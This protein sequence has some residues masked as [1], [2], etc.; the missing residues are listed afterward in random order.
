MSEIVDRYRTCADAFAAKITAVAPD[1]WSEQ[2]PCADWKARDVVG[3][4]LVMHGAMLQPLGRDLSPA[5]SID[6][7]PLAAFRAARADI[8]ALLDDP[9][10]ASA[11]TETPAGRMSIGEH[12][13]RVLSTDLVLHGWDLA[14]ATG[15]DDTI[16]PCEV[17]RIWP[18]V[19][20]IPDEL[21]T[22][23]AFRPGLTVFGPEVALPDD[24]SRQDRLLAMLGR[25]PRGPSGE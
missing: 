14:R 25:D 1:Q 24:A 17:E 6:D 9:V 23:G 10:S 8:E 18:T 7:D 20:D 3:H 19:Q 22:P 4:I 21:R 5:P 13:D 12:V 15:Q 2:S 11:E 16:D